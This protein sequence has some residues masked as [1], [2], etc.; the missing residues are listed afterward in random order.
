MKNID[1]IISEHED[2]LRSFARSLSNSD[3]IADDLVQDTWL[4]S[5]NHYY[6][7]SNLPEKKQRS[8]LFSVLKNR[9]YDLCRQKKREKLKLDEKEY[10]S[11][12]EIKEI[13]NWEPFLNLL[14]E[15]EKKIIYLR[16]WQGKNSREIGEELRLS[17]STVRWHLSNGLKTLRN[18]VEKKW[19]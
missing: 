7:L 15:K 6:L 17:D 13:I 14:P 4:K 9:F 12:S 10:F 5:L 18:N 19:R 2:A 11:P 16:F 1:E 3:D 8:W